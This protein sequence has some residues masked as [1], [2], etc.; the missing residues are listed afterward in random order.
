MSLSH[1]NAPRESNRS[2]VLPWLGL[3]AALVVSFGVW[4]WAETILVP[5][6]TAQALAK[7]VPIG[8]NSDLYPRW[9]G[10]R[11]SLLH[12]RDPYGADVTR[13]IQVGFY[14]RPL[15]PSKASDPPFQES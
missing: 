4:Y 14:G 11:E 5:T 7:G 1:K 2:R 12:H 9:L 15:D 8:N 10:A 6:H 13:E 3:A